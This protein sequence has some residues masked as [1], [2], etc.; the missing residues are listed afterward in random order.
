[1]KSTAIRSLLVSALT[2]GCEIVIFSI[3][4][5]LTV[6]PLLVLA[7][8]VVGATGA[9]FN[10]LLNRRWAF[11]QRAEPASRQARR[12]A[13]TMLLSVSLGTLVWAA[14]VRLTPWDARILHVASMVCVWTMVTYPIL[15]GWV[16]AV[17]E[18][19]EDLVGMA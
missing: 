4:T 11:K 10:F 8:W 5:V 19:E 1:M 3:C 13:M 9:S 12:Y 17:R 2:A 14:L 18:V 7:R 6:G 16:F 15:R